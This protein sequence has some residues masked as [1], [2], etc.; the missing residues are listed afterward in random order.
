MSAPAQAEGAPLPNIGGAATP[1][2]SFA[3]LA[4]RYRHHVGRC[5][6]DVREDIAQT[7]RQIAFYVDGIVVRNVELKVR[8]CLIFLGIEATV[9]IY[10]AGSARQP[11]I[12]DRGA[13][14]LPLIEGP[15]PGL[16]SPEVRFGP[17]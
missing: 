15:T 10:I 1:H 16:R 4:K 9:R 12:G 11:T 7:P 8:H 3:Q 14:R 17:R 5:L 2:A 13:D 6:H